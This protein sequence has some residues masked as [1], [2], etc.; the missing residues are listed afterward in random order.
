MEKKDPPKYK[1]FDSSSETSSV[2]SDES[3]EQTAGPNFADFA[4]QLTYATSNS[5]DISYYYPFEKGDM[6]E[7]KVEGSY[8]FPSTITTKVDPPKSTDVTTLYLIDS[9][10]RDKKAF[11]QPTSLT[12]RLPRVY[13]NVKSIQLTQVKMLCSFYYFSPAKSNIYLP[14]RE[15][16]RE[17]ITTFNGGSL[18]K[19]ITIRQGTFGINDLLK[20]IQTG[21]NTTPVFYDFPNGFTDFINIFTVNGD[22]SINFNQPGDSYYDRLNS[23]YIDNPT[24]ATILSYYWGSR[25]AGLLAYSMDQL[26]VAYYYPVFYEVFL[27]SED[28]TAKPFLNLSIPANLLGPGETVYSHLIFNMSGINDPVALYLINQNITLL[29][30]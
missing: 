3:Q 17:S 2:G 22:F 26:K 27:D 12:L 5:D 7:K 15:R 13:R 18:T 23:K 4:R 19:K 9:L 30:Q 11:P 14:V 21:M 24:M 1:E 20:E 6:I 29:D 16:G 28:T 8:V 25:Y 10:N